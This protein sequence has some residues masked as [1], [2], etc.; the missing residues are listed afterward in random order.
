MIMP[1]GKRVLKK[2]EEIVREEMDA[3]GA[4]ELLMPAMIP[5]ADYYFKILEY[6]TWG[7]SGADKTGFRGYAG[8]ASAWK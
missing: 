4:Q 2:I 3:A 5:D 8:N 1:M 6:G 7:N